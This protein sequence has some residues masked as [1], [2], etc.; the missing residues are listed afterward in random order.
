MLTKVAS[1]GT[2]VQMYEVFCMSSLLVMTEEGD[3]DDDVKS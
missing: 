3:E 1:F 2:L